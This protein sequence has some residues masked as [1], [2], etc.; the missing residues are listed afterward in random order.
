ME[1]KS[2]AQQV[3]IRRNQDQLSVYYVQVATVA[4]QV[5][6]QRVIKANF[7]FQEIHLAV[8]T[9][10]KV[11]HAREKLLVTLIYQHLGAKTDMIVIQQGLLM[12]F[13]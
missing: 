11:M 3:R 12:L 13:Y 10:R 1:L 8:K 6:L 2:S 7:L 5:Q 9:A 4:P